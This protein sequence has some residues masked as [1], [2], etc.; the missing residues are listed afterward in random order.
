MGISISHK[1]RIIP[2]N[3]KYKIEESK[4]IT[5][6]NH[7]FIRSDEYLRLLR[8]NTDLEMKISRLENSSFECI[9][10]YNKDS[11]CQQKTRCNHDLCI[12]CYHLLR[13][14]KCPLCRTKLRVIF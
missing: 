5:I 13:D 6:G 7:K 8:L 1:K 14:K 4:I 12:N 9:V 10:C 3:N 11:G 2:I